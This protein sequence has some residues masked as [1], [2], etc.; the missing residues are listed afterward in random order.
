MAIELPLTYW[1]AGLL[2]VVAG[3]RGVLSLQDSWAPGYFT[4]LGTVF[5]WYFIEP[6]YL[7]EEFVGFTG[8]TLDLGFLGVSI[9]IVA[10]LIATPQMV[11]AF[12]PRL[13]PHLRHPPTGWARRLNVDMIAVIVI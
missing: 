12:R 7:P 9:F 11:R 2:L 10:F 4:V 1:F 8:A 13:P 5:A 6:F 3:L